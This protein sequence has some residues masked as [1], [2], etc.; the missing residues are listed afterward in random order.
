MPLLLS[1]SLSLLLLFSLG[2]WGHILSSSSICFHTCLPCSLQVVSLTLPIA[3]LLSVCFGKNEFP[4]LLC[5]SNFSSLFRSPCSSLTCCACLC[6]VCFGTKPIV[7][8]IPLASFS[9][10]FPAYLP[11][12]LQLVSL[13][14]LRYRASFRVSSIW[15]GEESVSPLSCLSLLVPL[16]FPTASSLLSLLLLFSLGASGTQDSRW[17]L[18]VPPCVLIEPIFS[19]LLFLSWL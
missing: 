17:L 2:D 10:T 18:C 7:R 6:S 19:Y 16:V 14:S 4:G 8:Y 9:T 13:S 15:D 3:I 1:L 11:T 5:F 12:C